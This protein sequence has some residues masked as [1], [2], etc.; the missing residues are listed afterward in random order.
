MY[1]HSKDKKLF[2]SLKYVNVCRN[3]QELWTI[4]CKAEGT[5]T[6]YLWCSNRAVTSHKLIA[7]GEGSKMDKHSLMEIA[8]QQIYI[9]MEKP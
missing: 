9:S 2:P 5:N 6:T 8:L 3:N 7:N 4:C 1:Q